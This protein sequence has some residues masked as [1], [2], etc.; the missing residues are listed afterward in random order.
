MEGRARPQRRGE[1]QGICFTYG[2]VRFR[3]TLYRLKHASLAPEHRTPFTPSSRDC[4]RPGIYR[5]KAD[6]SLAGAVM[7]WLWKAG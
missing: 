5:E 4:P 2:N 7:E 3:V 6:M 1:G